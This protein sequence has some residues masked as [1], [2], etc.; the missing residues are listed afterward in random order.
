MAT[1]TT[2]AML[3]VFMTLVSGS[4]IAQTDG[5]DNEPE[6]G[7]EAEAET[8][9]E[10]IRRLGDSTAVDPNAEWVPSFNVEG[11]QVEI[12][13]RL[14][15]AEDAFSAGRLLS[16]VGECAVD[17]FQS[18]LAIEPAQA[19]AL[20]GLD[21]V[22][23]LL[24]SQVRAALGQGDRAEALALVSDIRSF[25]PDYGG[26]EALTTLIDQQSE[27]NQLLE[28]A[29]GQVADGNLDEPAG[30]NALESY[31]AILAIESSHQAALDGIAEIVTMLEDQATTALDADDPNAAEALLQRAE[32][33]AGTS[34][35]ITESRQRLSQ[36]R[37]AEVMNRATT[38]LEAG[39]LETA[40]AA[41]DR[42]DDAGYDADSVAAMR[43][44]IARIVQLRSYPPG[45]T[46][47]DNLA[48]GGSG[49]VMVVIPAGEFEMGSPS[50]DRDRNDNEGPQ[51]TIRF[52]APFA[53]AQMEV[54]VAEFRRFVDAT[55]HVT[56]AESTGSSTIYNVMAGNLKDDAGVT[57]RNDF[58]GQDANDDD[59]VVH[60]SW[61]DAQAYADWL[62]AETGER[63][64]LPS[65]AEFEY[66]LRAGT[67]TLY[68]WGRGS[69]RDEVE[70]LTGDGD[71]MADR[72][73]WPDP[74]ER[75][76]D[77]H[78]GPA[79]RGSFV[80]NPF[81][82]FDMGGNPM[83]WVADCYA[84][85][86]ANRPVNGS[87]VTQADCSRRVLRGGSW[88]TPPRMARSSNRVSSTPTRSTA[89]AGFRVARDL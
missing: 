41:L 20:A 37:L 30:G 84:S 15:A 61:N 24:A 45:T 73:Q 11:P 83:E 57:W 12:D 77:G 76:D 46:L 44:E 34:E 55:G 10:R 48:S 5:A 19:D 65:E 63:Y 28:T 8:E 81:G 32:A 29:R 33:I 40:G 69:P 60:V 23:D 64:R 70:N 82:L 14:R 54:S 27:V 1:K 18:V 7:T 78:W 68:W 80:A 59:P 49:P 58:S 51:L 26:L 16:P 43:S 87:A 86:L 72:W 53:M 17:L 6:T 67:T 71:R 79:Q 88:A 56:E 74:F 2:A 66:A 38:A 62:A 89:I 31:R 13:R 3:A 52:A 50:S 25:R 39:D 36:M 47:A 22:A 21:R 4:I 75:Y 9:R 42:L 85:S 35:S